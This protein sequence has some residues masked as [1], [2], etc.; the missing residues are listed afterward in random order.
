MPRARYALPLIV[1]LV[2]SATPALAERFT[3]IAADLRGET[4]I[5]EWTN[6]GCPFVSKHYRKHRHTFKH[7][8]GMTPWHGG[9]LGAVRL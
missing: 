6:H 8:I 3:V 4:V 5:L 1:L 9:G 7:G 2:A